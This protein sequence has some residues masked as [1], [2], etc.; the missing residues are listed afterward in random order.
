M[1]LF[2]D[3]HTHT[4]FSDGKHTILENVQAAKQKNLTQIA[5]T[6]HGYKHKL[7]PV[8]QKHIPLI[9]R[10]ID[11]ARE[12]YNIEVLYGIEANLISRQGDID[13][14]SK[15]Q[16]NFDVILLGFH[17]KVF[18]KNTKEWFLFFLPNLFARLFGYSKKRIQINTMAVLSA[19]EKNNIDI[20]VHLGDKFKVDMLKIARHCK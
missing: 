20:L 6:D 7:F 12:Q 11:K 18:A 17:Q 13:L 19:I 8:M 16:Q 1:R 5:I 2:G 10:Q 4:R 15:E 3:Y 14:T 9:K